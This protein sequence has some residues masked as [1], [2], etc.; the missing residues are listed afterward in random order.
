MSADFNVSL[1][2]ANEAPNSLQSLA[3]LAIGENQPVGMRVGQFVGLDPDEDQMSFSLSNGLGDT[4]NAFFKLDAN[5]TLF[6]A[7]VLDFERNASV[8]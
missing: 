7:K 1:L 4:G 8:F 5:G 2:D 3:V 6:S